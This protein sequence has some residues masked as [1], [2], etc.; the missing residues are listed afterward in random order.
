MI[1]NKRF[2]KPDDRR[3]KILQPYDTSHS[4]E[5]R[6]KTNSPVSVVRLLLLRFSHR[7]SHHM[8]LEVALWKQ[9]DTELGV[10]RPFDV[11]DKSFECVY[12]NT[13]SL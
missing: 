13:N 7:P 6:P 4:A 3:R 9:F 5:G 1:E 11:V 12:V 2:R 8:A 10:F